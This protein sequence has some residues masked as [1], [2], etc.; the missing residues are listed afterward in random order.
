MPDIP[1]I[2]VQLVHIE[3]P[4]KGKIEEYADSVIRIG[5]NPDCQ[6]C[7]P[8]DLTVVSRNHAEI[9]REGN[10][11][12]LLDHSTNGTF[13]NGKTCSETFLKGGDV[14]M[15]GEGGPKVSFL[16]EIQTAGAESSDV[17]LSEKRDPAVTKGISSPPVFSQSSSVSAGSSNEQS[18]DRAAV[19]PPSPL[20][21]PSNRE[22]VPAMGSRPTQVAESMDVKVRAP[23][24]IQF[25]PTIQSF[26]E[27]PVVVGK[28]DDCDF[29]INHMD[30]IDR[31]VQFTFYE[32]N[33]WVKDLTGQ[34]LITINDTPV[35]VQ[36]PLHPGSRLSL[37]PRGPVF[38]FFNGGRLVEVTDQ[39]AAAASKETSDALGPPLHA[40]PA[41]SHGGKGRLILFIGFLVILIAVVGGVF[42]YPGSTDGAIVGGIKEWWARLVEAIQRFIG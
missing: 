29:I 13:V 38:Q 34:G 37:G 1:V 31:H 21:P 12:K 8:K 4:F 22:P 10:R 28:K 2:I 33:Y 35:Q 17:S 9:V 27:L 41:P 7:F 24:A 16:T 5:R 32:D 39:L 30:V 23:L 20:I 3:G 11:F 40:T 18:N 42:F 14:V 19:P 15:I 36:T 26:Q 25:G 6:I